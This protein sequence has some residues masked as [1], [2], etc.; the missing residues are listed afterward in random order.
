MGSKNKLA[1]YIL[2]ILNKDIS[3]YG[4]YIEPFCG[5]CN[6][7]DKVDHDVIRM[8]NDSNKYI[9]SL[10]SHISKGFPIPD[11]ISKEEYINVRNN[12]DKFS[13]WYVGFAGFVCSFRGKFFGG[14][15]KNHV[16]KKDGTIENYQKEQIDNLKRQANDLIG[17]QYSIRSYMD[18]E[19]NNCVI[20]CDPPYKNTT[21]YSNE[22]SFNHE[23]FW[24]WC[25]EQ[26]S[27]GNKIY[28]SEY[29]APNDFKCVW[30]K[31]V[32]VTLSG[33][34]K[35]ASEKLFTVY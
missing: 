5:G 14:Y 9:V 13:D 20:Y 23:L 7:I 16:I 17:I 1:K 11:Y 33:K 6:I 35:T 27:K 25:R 19:I 8:A 3:K 12:K 18:L 2:P 34:K 30:E 29:N 26:P 10:L 31:D 15:V 24:N 21:N 4:K 32:T 28:I 22:D